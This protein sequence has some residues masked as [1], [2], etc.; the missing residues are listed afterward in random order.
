M[1]YKILIIKNNIKK[2]LNIKK[3]GIDWWAK[4]TPIEVQCD[5]IS[6]N[7]EV[8]AS[9]NTASN[10]KFKAQLCYIGG[11]IVSKI[12]S[13]VP[14]GKYNLVALFSDDD[15]MCQRPHGIALSTP[16]YPSTYFIQVFKY[17][18]NGKTFNHETIHSQ[19]Y[20][21]NSLGANIVDPMDTYILNESMSV[22]DVIN[23]N[24]EMALDKLKTH[25]DKVCVISKNTNTKVAVLTRQPS[26]DKETLGEMICTN[27][28][29]TLTVKTLE[30]PWLNNQK[31]ISC[32]PTGV[33]KCS[34]TYSLKFPTGTYQVL[35]VS[36]RSGIR[37][38]IANYYKQV[39]GCIA[40]GTELKDINKDG[41]TD[42]ANSTIA[43]NSLKA[44]F[45][46]EDFTLIIK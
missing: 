30:L 12:K 39:E 1:V 29:N 34:W 14:E 31:N 44:F 11:D 27:G 10:D 2:K 36:G 22:D 28:S 4:N 18:D 17:N 32:I 26:T 13:I 24:R 25:W 19:I 33:Y 45:G 43:F 20:K 8:K 42:T 7:W 38:H 23:T 9:E 3:Y 5:E 15:I 46:K 16:I 21:A 41:I 37:L 35:N 6:T 40:L